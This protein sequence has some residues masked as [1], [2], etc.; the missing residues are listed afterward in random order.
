M[1][2]NLTNEECVEIFYNALCDGMAYIHTGYG[3]Q[4]VWKD[5]DYKIAKAKLDN[6]CV[7]DV[8]IQIL[9]DGNSLFILDTE[10]EGQYNGQIC[11]E[12]VY[13]NLPLTPPDHLNDMIQEDGDASTCDVI[14]QTVFFKEIIFG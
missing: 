12:D 9:K 6:P 10:N 13:S 5:Q 7:E 2:I 1:T 11:I 14:L 8:I 4:I 3:L